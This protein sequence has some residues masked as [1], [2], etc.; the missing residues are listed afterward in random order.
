MAGPRFPSLAGLYEAFPSAVADI[1]LPASAAD[2]V[3]VLAD[4][5]REEAWPAAISL[6]AYLLSRRDAVAWGCQ[7]L[8]R[9]SGA[10]P[11]PPPG[12][13]QALKVAEA[14][15]ARP[16]EGLR[17]LALDLG[18][19][20]D[21]GEPETWMALAAGW[22]GGSIGPPEFPH[23]RAPP[24]QTA[25]AVRTGL[26][27][28]LAQLPPGAAAAPCGACIAQASNLALDLA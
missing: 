18:T 8:R 17:R 10:R 24:E 4:L 9:F 22:S 1:G 7:S 26:F 14:W 19:K 21:A 27:L 16:E 11:V 6:A 23:L 12:A 5:A 20:A 13:E 15:A 2:C 3:Q 28:V 25:R